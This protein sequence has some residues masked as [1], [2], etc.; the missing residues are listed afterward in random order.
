[1]A[2]VF[3]M[4]QR[5][6]EP[7]GIL[8]LVSSAI[9]SVGEFVGRYSAVSEKRLREQTEQISEEPVVVDVLTFRSVVEWLTDHRPAAKSIQAVLLRERQGGELRMTTVFIAPSG[10]PLADAR[11]HLRGRVQR[12]LELDQELQEFFGSRSMVLFK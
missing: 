6:R 3:K 10:T 8:D 2:G 7:R 11:G 9:I 1:M 4:S 5:S 12:A